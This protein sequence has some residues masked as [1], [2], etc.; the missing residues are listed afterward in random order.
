[1]LPVILEQ[2][3]PIGTSDTLVR[4][5]PAPDFGIDRHRIYMVQ[6][7]LFAATAAGLW[8]FLNLRRARGKDMR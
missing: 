3:A 4:H 7:F 1:M 2:T 6:W 8:L 5:W